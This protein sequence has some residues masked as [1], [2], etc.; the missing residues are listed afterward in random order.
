MLDH[1]PENTDEAIWDIH[2]RIVSLET[3]IRGTPNT[4]EKGM[5][6]EVKALAYEVKNS[7]GDHEGRLKS[8]EAKC[9]ER[10]TSKDCPPKDGRSRRT[11]AAVGSLSG[12]I[13]VIIGAALEW[14]ARHFGVG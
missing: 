12:G 4:D 11:V 13:G 5:V 7:Y 2:S 1:K 14:A 9:E 8:I 10:T 3:T 6:G